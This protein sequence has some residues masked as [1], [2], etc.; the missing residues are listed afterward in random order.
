MV[1]ESIKQ[2]MGTISLIMIVVSVLIASGFSAYDYLREKRRLK[3]SF[4]E[5]IDPIS[6]RLANSLQK[7]LWFLDEALTDKLIALE[8]MDKRIYAVVVRESDGKTVFA[9]RERDDQWEVVPSKG[10]IQGNFIVKTEEIT[11]EEKGIGSV[12]LHFTTRFIDQALENLRNYMIFKVLAMGTLLTVA[13]LLVV[14]LSLVKPVSAIAHGLDLVGTEVD[15]AIDRVS[16]GSRRLT[17]GAS[18]QASAVEETS[19][20]LEEMNAM[21]QQ[22]A[23]HLK[24][25]NNVMVETSRVVGEAADAMGQLTTSIDDISTTGEETRKIIKTI[26]E[27][28]FQTNLLALN[29]AVEAA[30]AGEVGA[31]FAVVADEVR[32][33]AMRS[34]EAARNTADLI[35]ASIKGIQNGTTW[36]R[37]AN[38][39]FT[40]VTAGS[41]KVEELLGEV[42]AASE[43]QAQGIRQV[44]SAMTE[45]DK[46]TQVNMA[47][48]EEM[49]AALDEI[50]GQV[51]RLKIFVIK[52][53]SLIGTRTEDPRKKR[54]AEAGRIDE[55]RNR[56]KAPRARE[57]PAPDSRPPGLP[58]GEARRKG[59][60][61][62][63][64]PARRRPE[65][66]GKTDSGDDSGQP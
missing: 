8:M 52:L 38:E 43:E 53:V 45:I 14:N 19:A 60:E 7:P 37:Q 42:T 26:E 27:I 5:I 61:K 31:G 6:K 22:N 13:L 1:Q 63:P 10:E 47:S 11:Y 59:T 33:L 44:S 39:A 12:S 2:R 64:K 16:E 40:N 17:E 34:S 18:R 15:G 25:A 4:A 62:A 55:G 9:A 57:L 65:R 30:R 36:V 41:K 56:G 46:V 48:A 58:P 3:E 32:N 28:A 50:N 29:A 35:E 49:A 23:Q 24:H 51:D 21:I 54:R 66:S 20:S